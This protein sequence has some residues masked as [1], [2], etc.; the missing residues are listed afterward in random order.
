MPPGAVALVHTNLP[1]LFDFHRNQL[2]VVDL[3]AASPTADIPWQGQ[4]PELVNYLRTCSITYIIYD[5]GDE[6]GLSTAGTNARLSDPNYPQWE[7][8]MIRQL[9]PFHAQLRLISMHW[10]KTYDDG[11]TVVIDISAAA[12]AGRAA[13]PT[14]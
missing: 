12:N 2:R 1:F 9:V 7:R 3:P 8:K 11:Q 10:P 6:A 14:P 4:G 5:Y 13:L